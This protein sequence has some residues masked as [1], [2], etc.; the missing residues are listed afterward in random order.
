[1]PKTHALPLRVSYAGKENVMKRLIPKRLL[2]H[3]VSH[4]RIWDGR[5]LWIEEYWRRF[6]VSRHTRLRLHPIQ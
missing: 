1:M 5:I 3:V 2:V 4:Y 6:P